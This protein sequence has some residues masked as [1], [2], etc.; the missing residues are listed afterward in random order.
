MARV[1]IIGAGPAG[2]SAAFHLAR[3]GHDVTII[4]RSAFPRVK[5]CGEFIS[6]SAT[7][8]LEA[9]VPARDLLD[10]GARRI[11][12][13]VLELGE[14]AAEWTLPTPAWSM[15]RAGLDSLL[16]ERAARVGASV[17]QPAGVRDVE[18]SSDRVDVTLADGS[19]LSADL[20]IHA[21]GSGRHDPA[22]PVPCDE[23][24][25]GHKCHLRVPGG[26][27]GVR[28]RAGHGAYVGTIQVEGDLATCALVA[29][30]S[31][32]GEVGGDAD[33][34]LR[35]L[36]PGYD[37]AWRTCEWK[38]CGVA[39]S[40]YIHPGHPR[41]FRIGN[42]A[43]AVDPIGGEGIGLALWAGTKLARLL[44]VS[45]PLTLALTHGELAGA[46]TRRLRTRLP[47]CR[48][49][50]ELLMRTGLVGLLWPLTHVPWLVMR[51]WYV[52]TGK[53]IRVPAPFTL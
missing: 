38:S 44:S 24:L 2:S 51:P 27:R 49:A 39:R 22:G 17:L 29:R 43:G 20:V 52:L 50:G 12:R 1:V 7:G 6:P 40:G 45:T 10:A 21:D 48:A 3:S 30:K 4:E 41:S 46:Y 25:V 8:L 26:V 13:L 15:S 36:W 31:R 35:R 34:M 16:L 37:G 23:R 33:E 19:P 32:I 53:P 9:I 28:M 47:A 18:Y 11:E 5:V 14:R 42:A